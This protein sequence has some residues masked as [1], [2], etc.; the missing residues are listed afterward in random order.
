[1]KKVE[2]IIREEK[3]EPVKKT[4]EGIGYYGMTITEVSGRGRQRGIPLKWGAKEYRVEF[5]PKLKIELVVLDEDV[6]NIVDAIV[7]GARTGDVGDGKIFIFPVDNA[8]R[9]RTGDTGGNAV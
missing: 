3:L 9:I 6:N 7:R 1:M 2:A 5:L 8:V 4:L